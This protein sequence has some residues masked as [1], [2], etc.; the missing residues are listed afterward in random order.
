MSSVVQINFQPDDK[1]LKQFGF[2]ALAGFGL[3]G[4]GALHETF[5]FSMGLG[6]ARVPVAVVFFALALISV[7]FSLVYPK[8]NQPIFVGL[9]LITFPIGFVLSYV[10]MGFMFFVVF[11]FV[12]TVF[13]LMGRD[14][15][16]R[17]YD[18]GAS[19]YWSQARP[20][21]P[22]EDYFKQY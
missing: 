14:S 6:G 8:G 21:R 18:P 9:S 16:G 5:I 3:L 20:E 13:R 2:I 1:T 17:S 4:F 19:S 15:M 22:R 7:A 10:I 11:G 12:A